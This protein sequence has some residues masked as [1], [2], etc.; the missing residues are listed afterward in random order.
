MRKG[1]QCLRTL[2]LVAI[3]ADL[4]LRAGRHY[5]IIC[6]VTD[7]TVCTGDVI[8]VMPTRVPATALVR[9]MAF[10]AEAILYRY[11]RCRITA[12]AN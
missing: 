2:I 3:E 10:N 12:E 11:W 7:M 4:R 8:A 5:R 1:F 6:G 9:T